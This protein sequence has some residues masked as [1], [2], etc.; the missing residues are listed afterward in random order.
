MKVSSTS[1]FLRSHSPFLVSMVL[2]PVEF[3]VLGKIE[4]KEPHGGTFRELLMIP[5]IRKILPS[6]HWA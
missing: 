1:Y 2:P 4:V 3:L 5:I 6:S